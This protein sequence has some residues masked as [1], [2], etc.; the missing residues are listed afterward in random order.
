MPV[1]PG[2]SLQYKVCDMVGLKNLI[3]VGELKQ[4]CSS[5]ALCMTNIKK[6]CYVQQLLKRNF[7]NSCIVLLQGLFQLSSW[8]FSR[9]VAGCTLLLFVTFQ[10]LVMVR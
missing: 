5:S 1:L 4:V 2:L 8:L 9:K 7:P 10:T 6:L 3:F